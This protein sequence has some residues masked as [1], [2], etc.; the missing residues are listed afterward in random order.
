MLFTSKVLRLLNTKGNQLLLFY[1]MFFLTRP[2][3]SKKTLA[4][5]IGLLLTPQM[6]NGHLNTP[7]FMHKYDPFIVKKVALHML[8][9][10]SFWFMHFQF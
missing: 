2:F 3:F 9:S 7:K 6:K 1:V 5:I 10:P 4:L 8:L